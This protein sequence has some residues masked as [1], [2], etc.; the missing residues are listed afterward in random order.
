MQA[1]QVSSGRNATIWETGTSYDGI[2]N[3]TRHEQTLIEQQQKRTCKCPK[4]TLMGKVMTFL[5]L[6][7]AMVNEI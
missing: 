1:S 2:W 6:R 7:G 5:T 3:L 4:M